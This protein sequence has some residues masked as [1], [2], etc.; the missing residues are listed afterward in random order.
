MLQC[1]KRRCEMQY[2]FFFTGLI[3]IFPKY[4]LYIVVQG[5][6]RQTYRIFLFVEKT[7]CRKSRLQPVNQSNKTLTFMHDILGMGQWHRQF[8]IIKLRGNSPCTMALTLPYTSVCFLLNPQLDKGSG[9]VEPNCYRNI[10]EKFGLSVL[11]KGH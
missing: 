11:G 2:F 7:G 8:I 3:N 9:T 5:T 6:P 1:R 10:R 4:F